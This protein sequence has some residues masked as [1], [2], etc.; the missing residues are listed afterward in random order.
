MDKKE[1]IK[2]GI[3]YSIVLFVA[4]FM[5]M[6]SGILEDGDIIYRDGI[7]GESKDAQLI[8]N[9]ED[10]LENYEVNLEIQPRRMTEQEAEAYFSKALEEIDRSMSSIEREIPLKKA[11]E[12][13]VV[14][15]E[16]NFSPAGIVDTDGIIQGK[17]IPEGGIL[18]TVSVVLQ[19]DS[20]EKVYR[21]P[22]KVD[23]PQMSV[24]EE[25]ELELLEW[26]ENQQLKEGEETFQL[27][28]E[29]GGVSTKWTEKKDH[30]SYKIVCLEMIS[31][32]LL[33]FARK[34]EQEENRRKCQQQKERQYP[35]IVNQLLILMEAG[36][37][38]RQAW[39][40]IAYQYIEKKKKGLVETSE[41]YEAIVQM[42][43]RLMEGENERTAYENFGNQMDTMC[44][45]R[46]MR[47]FVH[48]LEKGSRDLCHHL[49][50]EA[51]QAYDKRLLM[52]K[53][54]GEE[55]STKMLI[56]MMLMMVLVMVIVMAP[57]MMSFSM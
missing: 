7:G 50:L 49:N 3:V 52:A 12:N 19:C 6:K 8:L 30:L 53:K 5:D 51:K 28:K 38:I 57:A 1:I 31:I 42:D 13:G 21:F 33:F 54:L 46:L 32:I 15:A 56:P 11:Y 4:V 55:A 34:K 37:T 10:I 35:E 26:V 17:N 25:V 44:Y 16:W 43:R 36:M 22:L 41:V 24:Q 29:L 14:K 23:K 47:L 27:P 45:R 18:L 39:H 48:N 9:V 40:R 2:L 20:Y